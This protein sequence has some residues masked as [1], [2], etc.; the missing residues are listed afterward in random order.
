MRTIL[1]SI[2]GVLG[3]VR[4]RRWLYRTGQTRIHLDRVE[5]LG[6]FME[7]EVVL[8]PGQTEAEGIG[9]ARGLM[10]RLGIAEDQL[11]EAAYLD[12]LRDHP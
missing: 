1:T 8:G 4:K 10:N 12:L 5:G 7:L 9:V 6:E 11:V 2:L 3:V